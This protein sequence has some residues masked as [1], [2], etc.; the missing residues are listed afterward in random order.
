M[1]SAAS[2]LIP[3]ILILAGCTPT[4][5]KTNDANSEVAVTEDHSG[6]QQSDKQLDDGWTLLFDGQTMSGWRTFKNLDNDSWEVA[7]G[8]LHCKPFE[9]AGKRAD[10]ITVDLYDN[11]ELV[12]DWK[13]SPQGNSGV[14]FRVTEDY[15]Q[16]Y[17][18]GPEY[19]IVDDDGYPGDVKDVHFSGSDYDMYAPQKKTVKPVGEWNTSRIVAQ[20]NHIEHWLNGSK[21][22]AYEIGSEDWKK[23]KA[24]SKW[25]DVEGYGLPTKGHIDL[26]DHSNEVWFR[27]IMIRPL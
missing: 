13:I 5:K 10:L 23:R 4:E 15:D 16:P 27:N 20:G 18:T 21:V 12:F 9:Q 6:S 2:W 3:P 19:Q 11:F 17:F 24:N 14:I 26:Q 7:E 22:V 25:S 1:K 8:T